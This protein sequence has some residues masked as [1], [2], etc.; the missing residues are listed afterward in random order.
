MKD[1][2]RIINTLLQIDQTLMT[3]INAPLEICLA[4]VLREIIGTNLL[5]IFSNRCPFLSVQFYQMT[6]WMT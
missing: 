3:D 4:K 6:M 2:V 1:F 5:I